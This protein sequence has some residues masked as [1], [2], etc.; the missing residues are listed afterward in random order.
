LW[1]PNFSCSNSWRAKARTTRIPVRFSWRVL[2]RAASASSTAV[3]AV[4][5]LRK[6]ITENPTMTGM[7]AT[8]T[9]V[10]RGSI[11][12]ISGSGSAIMTRA[13]PISTSWV[14]RKTRKVSTSEVHRCTRSPVS[15]VS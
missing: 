5:T 12:S 1:P 10:M 6:K 13:R 11:A 8:E 4:W 7:S 3:N 15:A 9:S 14:E 2:V